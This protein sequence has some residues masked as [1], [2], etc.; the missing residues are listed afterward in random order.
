M[1]RNPFNAFRAC[2]MSGYSRGQLNSSPFFIIL[3][4][5]WS[6]LML[7][8]DLACPVVSKII[9]DGRI[10]QYLADL[11]NKALKLYK[12]VRKGRRSFAYHDCMVSTL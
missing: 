1:N 4:L 8:T 3:R 2:L 6:Y 12:N 7:W 11:L 10:A 5:F 9:L